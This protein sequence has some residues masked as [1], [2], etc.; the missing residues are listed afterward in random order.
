[1][2]QPKIT[3]TFDQMIDSFALEDSTCPACRDGYANQIAHELGPGYCMY[4]DS[5]DEIVEK[6]IQI[7]ADD[8]DSEDEIVEK[9]RDKKVIPSSADIKLAKK[10]AKK[11][12]KRVSKLKRKL[13]KAIEAE[14]KA[15]ALVD[16]LVT[17]SEPVVVKKPRKKRVK[18]AKVEDTDNT[19]RALVLKEKWINKILD[20][21]KI[22]EVRGANSRI[23]GRV[24]LAHKKQ[25]YGYATLE[26]SRK[27]TIKEL[28]TEE[29]KQYHKIDDRK[30]YAHY[31]KPH[32]WVFSGVTKF[33]EPR[34]IERKQG[35]VIWVKFEADY[36]DIV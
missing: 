10:A 6:Q 19:K 3:N 33:E 24:F 1:M 12:A 26:S 28:D 22:W 5:E 35:Q 8:Y 7:Q 4:E 27:T 15:Q 13:E 2:T 21:G 18:K 17:E 34:P 11:A 14:R 31:K 32:I 23:R 16:S 36:S 25:I 30:T 20:E 9:S 29:S